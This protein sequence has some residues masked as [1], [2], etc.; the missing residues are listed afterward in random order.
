M[1]TPNCKPRDPL[2]DEILKT[3]RENVQRLLEE[4]KELDARLAVAVTELQLECDHRNVV[5]YYRPEG[6]LTDSSWNFACL[7]CHLHE[8]HSGYLHSSFEGKG[9]PLS[10]TYE[11]GHARK[12]G[13]E[14]FRKIE[15]W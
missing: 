2:L 12:V 13:E 8:Y 6:T 9:Y 10:R 1:S 11:E 3:A 14:E 7:E 4:R 5:Y 15:R